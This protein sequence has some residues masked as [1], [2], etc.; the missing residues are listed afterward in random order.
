MRIC[1]WNSQGNPLNDAIKLNILNHLL[2]IEQCNVVMIQECGKFILP[3]HFSGIYHYVVV[4]QAGA[5]NYRGNTCIIAD[6]NFVA[7][8]HY[9]I[10]GTGRSAI[11][12]NYNGYNIYTLHC[13]S[14]SG[15]VGDI[16]DLVHHAVSPFIIGGD[17][18]STP[19]ELSENL[20]IMTQV[21]GVGREIVLILLV[22]VCQH[23]FQVEN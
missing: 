1:T 11:C 16:R 20:R 19:S 21:S 8:I 17:M 13:E 6:L 22:V 10:S 7:S 15:A 18:N 4:E 3:A 2:T 5:Y 23:I 9:L 14:G 12:L